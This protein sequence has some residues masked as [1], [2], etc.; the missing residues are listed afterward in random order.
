MGDGKQGTKYLSLNSIF[1][2]HARPQDTDGL[3]I[4]LQYYRGPE[5]WAAIY[6]QYPD[7]NW[8]EQAGRR[9]TGATRVSF[10]ASGETGRE[11]VEFKAGGIRGKYRD[12]FE[13]SLG[14]ITLSQQWKAYTIDLK[15]ADT[16]S[17]IG[18]F[19]VVLVSDPLSPKAII[20]LDDIRYE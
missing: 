20:Y 7:G 16:S 11:V 17:V 8:G 10:W 5:G 15:G 6:W 4:R 9:I 19:C 3:C 1:R 12:T 2:G 13:V 14:R 18:A